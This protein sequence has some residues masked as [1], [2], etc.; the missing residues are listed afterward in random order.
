MYKWCNPFSEYYVHHQEA[1]HVYLNIE[2]KYLLE[3]ED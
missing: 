2:V 3:N 1:L